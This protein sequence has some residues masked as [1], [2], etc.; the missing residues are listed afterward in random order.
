MKVKDPVC[1]MTIGDKDAAATS[2][3]KGT[4]YYFCSTSC[5]EKFEKDP[6]SHVR[7]K[8]GEAEHAPAVKPA[9]QAEKKKHASVSCPTCSKP[10]IP[11]EPHEHP[12]KTE[13]TCPMHP[14]VRQPGHGSCPKCAMARRRQDRYDHGRQQDHG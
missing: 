8:S 10:L 13:Y 11:D 4:T 12:V 5:K 1:G 9:S 3:Y 2:A 7:G 14:E 6:A